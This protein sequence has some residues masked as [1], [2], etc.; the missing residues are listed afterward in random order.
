MDKNEYW[1]EK[2]NERYQK[3][4]AE[5]NFNELDFKGAKKLAKVTKGIAKTFVVIVA[6][7]GICA[8]I[9][10]FL[11]IKGQWQYIGSRV[12]PDVIENLEATYREKFKIVSKEINDTEEIY[13]ISPKNNKKIIFTAYKNKSHTRNDYEDQS[14]KYFVEKVLP[15]NLKNKLQITESYD[16]KVY[17]QETKA[18]F[19]NYKIYMELTDFSQIEDA[20]KAMKEI[21]VL[22]LKDGK[23]VSM[24]TFP[25]SLIKIGKYRSDTVYI[26]TGKSEEEA[27]K[28]EKYNYIKWL[29]TNNLSTDGIP[30]EELDK[31]RPE[32]LEVFVNGKSAKEF[33]TGDKQGQNVGSFI[34]SATYNP[35]IEEYEYNI[36]YLISELGIK[37]KKIALDGA[38]ES[39]KYKGKTY[40]LQYV[41]KTVEKG[42][43]P[44]TCRMSYLE[45]YFG[46]KI[47]YDYENLK[48]YIEM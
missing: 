44:Y 37:D 7:I 10:A 30:K 33:W 9:I 32:Y 8:L 3:M 11:Y 36:R 12:D 48:I 46:A 38:I 42:K 14:K 29:K 17:L 40:E 19:L 28:E 26:D 41:T 31:Y 18:T 5:I 21:S 13:K 45:Q 20:A 2:D 16:N 6:I 27:I 15:E 39:I 43:L 4:K 1:N 23:M 25:G 22:A 47:T 24:Y 35:E 34:F